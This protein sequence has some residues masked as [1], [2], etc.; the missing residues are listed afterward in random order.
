[1]RGIDEEGWE[2]AELLFYR[3][4]VLLDRERHGA[5]RYAP[6][7]DFS[8][9]RDTNSVPLLGVEFFEASRS[10]PVVFADDAQG[11]KFPLA[12]LSL[13]NSRN[14][15]VRDDGRWDSAYTPAFVRRYPFALTDDKNVCFD[16]AAAHFS[17]TAASATAGSPDAGQALFEANAPTRTLEGVMNFLRHFDA[18]HARTREFCVAL[19]ERDMF[20]P[21]ALQVMTADRQ[22][23][24]MGGLFVVDEA[25]L[26]EMDAAT[27]DTWFRKGWLAWVYA[28]L[29]S[30]GALKRLGEQLDTRAAA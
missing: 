18:E 13:S 12:L 22:P 21:F 6:S 23:L 3:E 29:H 17:S 26:Q 28:Q 8:F 16:Q 19:T 30:L 1:M 4:P 27:V 24:R 25:K 10:L 14:A 5:L 2:M 15:Q 11:D 9:A 20:K 7:E